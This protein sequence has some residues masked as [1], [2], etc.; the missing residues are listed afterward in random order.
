MTSASAELKSHQHRSLWDV[1]NRVRMVLAEVLMD[2]RAKS[3]TWE[4]QF[5]RGTRVSK[6]FLC[7]SKGKRKTRMRNS[8]TQRE[9]ATDG[10]EQGDQTGLHVIIILSM[11]SEDVTFWS[12]QIFWGFKKKRRL[13]V[14][15]DH[16]TSQKGKTNVLLRFIHNLKAE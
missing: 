16:K 8:E 15:P 12:D 3:H 4:W 13:H 6:G 9:R 14:T 5:P 1:R 11:H 10:E 2:D 7:H